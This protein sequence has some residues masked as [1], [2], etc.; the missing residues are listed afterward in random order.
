MRKVKINKEDKSRV[1]L[2]ELLPYEVPMLFS[3][4]GFYNVVKKNQLE[5]FLEKIKN[6]WQRKYALPFNYEIRKNI[7][8][9]TR[10]LSVIHPFVQYQF[11]ELF[12]KYDSLMLHLCT[13]SPF[14]L[15]K[16]HKIAK[17]YYSPNFVFE[18]ENIQNPDKEVEP[19]IL[20]YESKYIKS[21]FTYKPIDLI[22]KFY[23]RNEFQRLEQRFN[24]MMEFDISKCFYHIYTHSITWAV[25]DKES[26]K[27]NSSAK[28]FEND[29]DKLMQISN[30][31]ETNGIVVGPE[32][33]R[34]FSEIILQQIDLNS[35]EKIN[36]LG[37]KLGVDYEIRRYVDDYFVFSNNT[38]ILESI[39]SIFKKELQFYKLYLNP[40]KG[41]T[42][43]SPFISEIAVGKSELKSV[44]IE[45][46]DKL[47]EIK[48]IDDNEV[49]T[50]KQINKPFVISKKFIKE[51]Q[52]IVKR[53]NL[54]YDTL[55]KDVVRFLKSKIV[56][57]FKDEDKLDIKN[58]ENFLLVIIDIV[59]YCYSVNVNTN[60]TFR[61]S[62]VIVLISKYFEN[63]SREDIKHSIFSKI[64]RD[65][66]FTL[67]NFHRK[68]TKKDTSIETLN[69]IL[70][71]NK[72]GEEYKFSSKKICEYFDFNHI[73]YFNYFQI[74]TLLYYFNNNQEYKIL[75][76]Q[77]INE[78][79]ERFKKERVFLDS[80]M[81]LLFFD[82]IN[83]PFIN[84]KDK[85]TI[86]R[87]SKYAPNGTSNLLIEKEIDKITEQ[88]KWFMGWNQ[89]IDLE[90][91]LKKKE[92]VSS[93]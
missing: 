61:I 7:Y 27:I 68:Q 79:C 9:D 22:Y 87:N 14:S 57:L 75:Q 64:Y 11:I 2:T 4:E 82:L 66:E 86:I 43:S 23:D 90:R 38:E 36:K 71:L 25:K 58:S 10:T 74:I 93:Y 44:L 30:Y 28:T 3:N 8:G 15:R 46:Y 81:T 55:S 91:V 40:S 69:L 83:C 60:T 53:N 18:E 42:K 47:F 41:D 1:L 92:W 48:V 52:V 29:F 67:K 45:F 85:R 56:I 89:D 51:F 32:I 26:A 84:I 33:S 16:I 62:Q 17:F 49:K 59:F 54:T 88:E 19:E 35:L 13:K 65:S 39:K 20:N 77:V 37:F 12:K 76:E 6:N 34:I 24:F 21:Y 73:E 72:L 78:S 31:N 63:K 5:Y 50:V 70:A 80:E